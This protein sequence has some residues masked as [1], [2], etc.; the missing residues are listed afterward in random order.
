VL[1]HGAHLR[2]NLC[3]R[4]GG[5]SG[6]LARRGQSGGGAGLGVGQEGGG[7]GNRIRVLAAWGNV[8]SGPSG[9]GHAH[10]APGEHLPLRMACFVP[11]LHA[12]RGKWPKRRVWAR[13]R[14]PRRPAVGGGGRARART[15]SQSSRVGTSTSAR[16]PPF[17]SPFASTLWSAGS[18]YASVLPL[19]VRARATTSLPS[20]AFGIAA[21]CTGVG[22]ANPSLPS[23]L[24]RRGSRPHSFHDI[25]AATVDL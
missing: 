18:R 19:P 20:R 7:V 21:A 2:G 4:G 11:L 5:Q 9:R 13:C 22:D 23:A 17:V 8:R 3:G 25:L 15:C 10:R 16:H 1:R 6:W 14:R 24:S 12:G